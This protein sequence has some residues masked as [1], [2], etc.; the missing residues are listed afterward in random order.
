MEGQNGS[1]FEF[2]TKER[3][4]KKNTT[5]RGLQ[6]AKSFRRSYCSNLYFYPKDCYVE[7]T[8]SSYNEVTT[9]P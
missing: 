5:T 3:F 7:D 1:K 2:L 4:L 9:N 6:I 8:L